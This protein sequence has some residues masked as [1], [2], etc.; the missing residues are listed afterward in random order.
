MCCTKCGKLK[1]LFCLKC[2]YINKLLDKYCGEYKW[3][4]VAVAILVIMLLTSCSGTSPLNPISGL[5]SIMPTTPDVPH[6]TD[7]GMGASVGAFTWVGALMMLAGAASM[8]IGFV[9]KK[10]SVTCLLTGVGIAGT[11]MLLAYVG[12]TILQ[13]TAIGMAL[14]GLS[15]VAC[16]AYRRWRRVLNGNG[17]D[18]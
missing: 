10:T 6:G 17:Q 7:G 4:A 5:G 3:S 1:Q 18:T 15:I 13:W 14:C 9:D 8:I 16:F 2:S 11:P 12:Q